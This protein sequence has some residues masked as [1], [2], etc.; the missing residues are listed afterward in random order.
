MKYNAEV[1]GAKIAPSSCQGRY[2]KRPA[3]KDK[4][5]KQGKGLML[6]PHTHT[7]RPFALS[8]QARTIVTKN[9]KSTLHASNQ[10]KRIN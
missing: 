5:K 7:S 8:P 3:E 1:M 4:R 2:P 9:T 6:Q 10:K